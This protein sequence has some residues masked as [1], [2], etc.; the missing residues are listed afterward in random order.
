MRFRLGRRATGPNKAQ[1]F[2][3]GY[4]ESAGF[5]RGRAPGIQTFR[6]KSLRRSHV[7]SRKREVPHPHVLSMGLP[8]NPPADRGLRGIPPAGREGDAMGVRRQGPSDEVTS[9]R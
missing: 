7:P 4:G 6:S 2:W 1:D 9:D 8:E 3:E 5:L